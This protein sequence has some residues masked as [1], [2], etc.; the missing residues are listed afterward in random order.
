MA[1]MTALALTLAAT[2]A[3]KLADD[4]SQT[5]PVIVESRHFYLIPKPSAVGVRSCP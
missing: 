4:S 5:F 1:V 2:G 3:A